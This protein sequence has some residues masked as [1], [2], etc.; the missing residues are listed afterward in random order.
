M[1]DVVFIGMRKHRRVNKAELGEFMG[2]SHSSVD[3]WVRR[4]CPFIQQGS[5]HRPWVFDI[6]DVMRW[7][8]EHSE[9]SVVD[10]P[11]EM[12]PQ[13]RKAWYDSEMVRRKLLASD[14][15]LLSLDDVESSL[16]QAYEIIS[17]TLIVIPQRVAE[18]GGG[19][20]E[21]REAEAVV[22]AELENLRSRLLTLSP[23]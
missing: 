3:R 23:R 10:D 22:T 11:E 14:R 5:I 8:Y 19:V 21:Q 13:D 20:A 15:E 4:G 1:A 9:E 12:T 7:R 16:A 2:V 18:A 17:N 6:V